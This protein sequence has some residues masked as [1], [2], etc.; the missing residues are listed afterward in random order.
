MQ[1]LNIN[2]S[3]YG[4]PTVQILSNILFIKAASFSSLQ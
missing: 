3:L 1:Y 4:R 2:N